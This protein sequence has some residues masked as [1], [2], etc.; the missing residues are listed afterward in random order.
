MFLRVLEYYNGILFLTTN[1]VGTLDEAF[2]SRIHISL[3]YPPLSLDQTLSIFDVNIEKLHRIELEREKMEQDKIEKE[4]TER[5]KRE[6]KE[7]TEKERREKQ[8]EKEK[9][10]TDKEKLDATGKPVPPKESKQ[11]TIKIDS[12]SI[13]HFASWHYNTHEPHERWNGRQIRSA[14]QIA[15]SLAQFDMQRMSIDHWDHDP[16][17]DAEAQ[18]ADYAIE[19]SPLLNYAQFQMVATAVENF[20]DYLYSALAANDMDNARTDGIRADD[21]DPFHTKNRPVYRPPRPRPQNGN[22]GPQS[23][24]PPQGAPPPRPRPARAESGR[25]PPGPGYQPAA[26][27][28]YQPPQQYSSRKPPPGAVRQGLSRPQ[29]RGRGSPLPMTPR[30]KQQLDPRHDS[31]YSGSNWSTSSRT[32]EPEAAQDDAYDAVEE[33]DENYQDYE[34]GHEYGYDEYADAGYQAEARY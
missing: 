24:G 11:A 27:Q 13:R 1:R 16:A 3:Y 28:T 25:G 32:P 33:E 5:E 22:Q 14:F 26:R 20:D 10:K 21:Y 17:N 9:E 34:E 6:K 15:Y 2:K 23:R 19:P 30:P 4:R 12:S 29:A 18:A 7:K 8:K 31:G